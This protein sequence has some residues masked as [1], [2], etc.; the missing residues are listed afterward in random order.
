MSFLT[1]IEGV[2]Y[3][4]LQ[5]Q[6]FNG[7]G[8]KVVQEGCPSTTNEVDNRLFNNLHFTPGSY[9]GQVSQVNV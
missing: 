1:P 3:N 9:K 8:I 4:R 5:L 6:L 2:C 7:S